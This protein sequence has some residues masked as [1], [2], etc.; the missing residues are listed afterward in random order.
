MQI[1]GASFVCARDCTHNTSI[2]HRFLTCA[3]VRPP[4]NRFF[5]SLNGFSPK[6]AKETAQGGLG[7]VDGEEM[8]SAGALNIRFYKERVKGSVNQGAAA[9]SPA[10]PRQPPARGQIAAQRLKTAQ[11]TDETL[12]AA[13]LADK[14]PS[15]T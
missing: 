12:S 10:L 7:S 3:A 1:A 9:P 13:L 15:V 8:P 14:K 6:K 4:A 11:K 2:L 5:S